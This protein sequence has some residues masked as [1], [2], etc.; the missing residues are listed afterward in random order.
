[1]VP[2]LYAI[3]YAT[4]LG[5][6][7]RHVLIWYDTRVGRHGKVIGIFGNSSS[8]LLTKRQNFWRNEIESI[9]RRQTSEYR[10]N[11]EIFLRQD[12]TYHE[13]FLLFPQYFQNSCTADSKNP[14]L[15]WER[16]NSL[17]QNHDFQQPCKR[18]FLKTWCEK[19]K[20][21]AT[22]ILFFFH[23]ICYLFQTNFHLSVIFILSY[24][25]IFSIWTS[26]KFCR[27]VN[28]LPNKP[29]FLRVCSTSLLKTLWKK[30]KL[31]VTSNFSFSH[32]VFYHF[33]EFCAFFIKFRIVVSNLFQL[34]SLKFVVWERVKS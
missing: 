18:R 6:P 20:M 4:G 31:L 26:L 8:W 33:G 9:S 16:F 12:R 32:S 11:C 25:F 14:G 27:L 1:M 5:I 29:W 13:E 22:S 28:P 15:A 7:F 24:L 30:K 19:E 23:N 2:V 3:D 34:G 17:P 10:S 21:L